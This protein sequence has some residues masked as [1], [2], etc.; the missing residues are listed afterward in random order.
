MD[1]IDFEL[2][3]V[4]LESLEEELA[5]LDPADLRY[6]SQ[7]LS[8]NPPVVKKIIQSVLGRTNS[9]NHTKKIKTSITTKTLPTNTTTEKQ[10]QKTSETIRSHSTKYHQKCDRLPERDSGSVRSHRI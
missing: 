8:E 5:K 10:K 4:D 1:K 9:R 7:L 3:N 6:L 2:E